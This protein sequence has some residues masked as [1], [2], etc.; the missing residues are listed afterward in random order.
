MKSKFV[1]FNEIMKDPN[2][3]LSAK[4]YVNE[5]EGVRKYKKK[6]VVIEAMQW[7]GENTL[8]VLKW[9]GKSAYYRDSLYIKT[10]EGEHKALVGDFIIQGVAGEFYPCKFEIFVQT[11]DLVD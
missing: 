4:D 3:S 1:K 9:V 6:P 2:L 8:E 5:V 7:T 10:L 11:Y